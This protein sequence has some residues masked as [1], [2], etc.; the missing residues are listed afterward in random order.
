MAILLAFVLGCWGAHR[1]YLNENKTL[2]IIMLVLGFLGFIIFIPLIITGIIALVDIIRYAVMSD[3][4]FN[5]R[6]NT[7]Q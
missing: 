2:G 7:P 4:E 1:L 3:E 5:T 6:F